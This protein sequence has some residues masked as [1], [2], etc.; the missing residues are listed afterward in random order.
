MSHRSRLPVAS[1]CFEQRPSKHGG[2]AILR[3]LPSRA[4]FSLVRRF[5]LLTEYCITVTSAGYRRMHWPHDLGTDPLPTVGRYHAPPSASQELH[6]CVNSWAPEICLITTSNCLIPPCL[7]S[8]SACRPDVS[9]S[10]SVLES[11]N[12]ER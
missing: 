8:L 2:K 1:I 6:A 3:S 12:C 7:I 5:P 11:I 4:V 9:L 10:S